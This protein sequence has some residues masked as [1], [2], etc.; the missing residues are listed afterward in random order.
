MFKI[1]MALI[2]LNQLFLTQ[3]MKYLDDKK[4][5]FN[6]ICREYF[7]CKEE[8]IKLFLLKIYIMSLDNKIY[9]KFTNKSLPIIIKTL[10]K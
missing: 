10:E 4:W 2:Y 5:L 7:G 3:M 9:F 8:S 1:K 6:S